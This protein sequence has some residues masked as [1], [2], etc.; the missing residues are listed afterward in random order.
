MN[1]AEGQRPGPGSDL[2]VSRLMELTLLELLR[3]E[4][5]RLEPGT[6]GLLSGLADPVIARS[7]LAC[8]TESLADGRWQG[9]HDSPVSR[10]QSSSDSSGL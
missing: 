6:K 8:M 4:V 10:D 1:D 2:V 7:L 5:L 3:S 9:L